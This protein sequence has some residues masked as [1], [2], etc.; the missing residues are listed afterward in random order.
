LQAKTVQFAK[1]WD[2]DG[3]RADSTRLKTVRV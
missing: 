2:R 1:S 3:L